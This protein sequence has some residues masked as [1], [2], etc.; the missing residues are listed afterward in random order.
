MK[1]A[2]EFACEDAEAALSVPFEAATQ[3]A[4]DV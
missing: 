3:G 2:Y 4:L 1:A